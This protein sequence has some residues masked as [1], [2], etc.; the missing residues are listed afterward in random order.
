MKTNDPTL[1]TAFRSEKVGYLC[2]FPQ[3]QSGTIVDLV[4]EPELQ[5]RLMGMGLFVGTRFRVLQK[6]SDAASTRPI[7]LAIG[8][9]RIALGRSIASK[10]L[11][12]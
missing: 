11:V 8:D 3:G 4:V 12:E 2:H 5:G 9:T 7:L 10:I 1:E 6:G